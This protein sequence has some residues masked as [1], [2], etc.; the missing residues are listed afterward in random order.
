MIQSIQTLTQTINEELILD[1]M[2]SSCKPHS[3]DL[4]IEQ[5]LLRIESL[6]NPGWAVKFKNPGAD[7]VYLRDN[8]IQISPDILGYHATRG[9]VHTNYKF[10][11]FDYDSYNDWL[12]I[13]YNKD[14]IIG[15]GDGE[16]LLIILTIIHHLVTH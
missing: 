14:E 6:D 15:T 11:I 12:H 9:L 5:P 8:T 2:M 3:V 4:E 1:W 7:D 16:K 10:I 13:K